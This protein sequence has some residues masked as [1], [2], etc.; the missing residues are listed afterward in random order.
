[1]PEPSRQRFDARTKI[2]AT[3]GPACRGADRLAELVD[4][5]VDVF[6]INTA[7]GTRAEHDA[8]LAAVRRA[9]AAAERPVAVLVDL[10]GPKI[11]L[12]DLPREPTRCDHDARFRFVRGDRPQAP[13]ELTSNHERLID[14]LSIGDRVMLADGTVGMRV[15]EKHDD[16]V[17][18]RVTAAGVLR[19]RQGI[20][21]PGVTLSVA[22]LTEQDVDNARWAAAADVDFVGLSFVRS[23]DDVLRLRKLLRDAGSPA[24]VVAK[25]ERR[26][27]LDAL[28]A[29][30]G[31]ADAVMVA[32]GDLGVEIDIAE[33]PVTQKR[34]IAACQRGGK[35]VI[36]ATQ[37]LDSMT[38]ATQPT[39]AEVTD[40]ANAILDGADAC[41]LSGETAIGEHPRRVV[42]TMRRVMSATER[43]IPGDPQRFAEADDSGVRPV[44]SA[45]VHGAGL[46]ARRLEARLV[47]IATRSG[48][49]ALVK[50]KLRDLVPTVGV[51]G[52]ARTLRRMCLY[53]GIRPLAGAPVADPPAL[54]QFVE[55]W[56]RDSGLLRAGH[57]VVFVTGTK[58]LPEAHNVITVREIP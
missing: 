30:I 11:R 43:L 40:V 24:L 22:A 6:R 46:I 14:E 42:E 13:D 27:A 9:G 10:A 32:R 53:W 56:G 54:E 57:R 37:M 29:I 17:V 41:A 48:A 20:N 58:I 44:T 39:R 55:N 26:E 51:S 23:A 2:V 7:H 19:S 47:V 52:S 45:V 35:P 8:A 4:A 50:S 34:I 49:T 31:A 28:D 38:H 33:I 15:V 16:S 25:I 18:C 21:L 5:G 3:V 36:V 12:G 1:M